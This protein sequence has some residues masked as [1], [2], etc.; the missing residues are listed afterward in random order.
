MPQQV[1]VAIRDIQADTFGRPIA[2]RTEG[3]AIR[4]FSDEVN[5]AQPNNV[6]YNHPEDFEL[7]FL[8]YYSEDTGKFE[9]EQGPRQ[10]ITGKAVTR[11]QE[12]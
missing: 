6:M 11:K 2:V 12:G 9:G 4:I 3:E 1:I 5:N 10:I 8:A 7:H